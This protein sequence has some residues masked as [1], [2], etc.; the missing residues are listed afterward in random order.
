M[1]NYRLLSFPITALLLASCGDNGGSSNNEVASANYSA[2]ITRTEY[3]IPHIKADDWGS[4]G[5]GYGYAYAQDN[6]CVVM[7]EV[8][9]AS[10]RSAELMGEAEGD[11][12]GD[13][14]FRY[15][16]GT[17]ADKEAALAELSIDGQNLATGYAAGLNRYLADTGVENLAE[18]DAGCR[19]ASWVQEIRPIDLYTYLSRIALGGS[20]DQGIVRK[21]LADVTGPT[22]SGS[23]STK[24]SV[25]WDAVSDEIKRNTQSMS[26]TNS[27]SN[28]IAL[29]GDATQTGYGLLLG[30]PHQPWQGSGRW[31]EAHLTIPGEYDVA[32]ASLQG[33]PWIGIGFNKD[34][35]WTHT[36]SFAT[37]FTL[38]DLKLNPDNPLQYEFDGAMRDITSVEIEAKVTL[39]DGSV[40]TRSHTFY[41]SHFGPIVNLASVNS[42]LGTWPIEGG[43][44]L[45]IRDANL[46]TGARSFDVYQAMGKASNLAELID[47]T[48]NIGIPVFHTLAADRFG[49]AFYGEVAV[50]PHVT[51]PQLDTC[52]KGIGSILK[53]AT[54]SAI[55]TLDGSTSACEWGEDAD[56]PAGSNVYGFEARPTITTRDYVANSNNSYWLSDANN[57]LTGFPV[58]F[59]WLGHENQQ[60]FLRTRLGSL[61]VEQRKNATDGLG[62]TPGFNLTNLQGL[63]Y[64]N[65]VHAATL[66]LDD[67]L[68]I[69]GGIATA[70]QANALEACTVLQSWDRKV[71]LDSVGAQVF[72]EFWAYIRS[73]RGGDY[74]NVVDDQTFW[75]VNFDASDPVNTPNGIDLTVTANTDLVIEGLNTAV[76]N[77]NAANVALD[78]PW[79][80]VQFL[81]R[82]GVPVPIHGGNGTMGIYGDIKVR[83]RE[84][85]YK[86]PTGGNSYIQ[87][88]TWNDSDCPIADTILTHSQSTDPASPYYGDQT[89]LYAMKQ[90]VRMPY[91]DTEIEAAKIGDTIILT[92]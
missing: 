52:V 48:K 44:I 37:R 1:F 24:A 12:D 50:V 3:G 54:N 79:Q 14:L 15:L 88:V 74:T 71:N 63:M 27:G 33:L 23:A 85:G 66:V 18:G 9:L 60:Q 29:G 81:E 39:A 87:T 26:T 61:M 42:A 8:I 75:D 82:N 16:F 58:V 47:A 30:N 20:S 2:E 21:A 76:E 86:N 72:T 92:Q 68:T 64:A 89:E 11:I 38:F 36:I 53:A 22:A 45:A 31:Y 5:Y 17:D 91:C 43:S 28:A 49:D 56:S 90:W 19:N 46:E 62:D 41:E 67:V 69:C 13:F 4:L 57:P 65:D 55:I 77:L 10:G 59:G 7:R 70:T 84:G 73:E 35:A 51:Q 32:G 34:I 6:F 80:N 25:D 40:E 83:L 78:E